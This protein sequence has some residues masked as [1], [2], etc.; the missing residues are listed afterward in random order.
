MPI[1]QMLLGVGAVATKTYVDDIFSTYLL[2]G[3]G[4]ARSINN[5]IDLS[6]EGGLVWVKNRTYSTYKHHVLADTTRGANNIIFSDN[7]A[8]TDT[9]TSYITGFNN[10]GFSL[11]T[12]NFVNGSGNIYASWT[13][14]KAPGFFDVV[15]WTGNGTAGRQISHNLGCAPGM[16]AIKCTSDNHNWAV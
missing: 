5:G 6:E 13:W 7:N 14:R 11:G 10:N 3:S 8:A 9:A 2:A 12:N 15:T 16:V 4:S 1:Q